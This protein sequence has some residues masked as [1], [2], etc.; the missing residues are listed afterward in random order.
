MNCE[1]AILGGGP[2]ALATAAELA[3]REISVAVV[4]DV[5]RMPWRT[6]EILPSAAQP[7]LNSLGLSPGD[8]SHLPVCGSRVFWGNDQENHRQL[9]LTVYGPSLQLVGT[10]LE[11]ALTRRASALGARIHRGSVRSVEFGED[12]H[13]LVR[14][15]AR[16]RE[17][18]AG[19]LVEARGRH[20]ESH[21]REHV[22]V[23]F[24]NLVCLTGVFSVRPTRDRTF[25]L[26]TCSLGWWYSVQVSPSRRSVSFFTDA[27][28]IPKS[29]SSLDFTFDRALTGA[30]QTNLGL[31]SRLK[32]VSVRSASSYFRKPVGDKL[33][34]VGD[35]AHC[36]D[37][38][39]SQGI[40]K[41]M[42]SGLEAADAIGSHLRQH[43]SG[44]GKYSVYC[45]R[46]FTRYWQMRQMLYS[47][48][49]RWA[50]APFW[51][52]RQNSPVLRGSDQVTIKPNS[53][54]PTVADQIVFTEKYRD[55]LRNWDARQ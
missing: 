9:D 15:G 53:W 10:S 1:V 2:A 44:L 7:V 37:P 50:K 40:W 22:P 45:L 5:R 52:R 31:C 21:H 29:A 48:E 6:G 19:I 18:C 42:E 33:L 8:I 41:A 55:D 51:A 14:Q 13:V 32:S 30:K 39:S 46:E 35:A 38:L 26:E 27:D 16:K 54:M 49:Q 20:S 23:A 4:T 17:I 36:F 3:R 34:F 47:L 12:W 43:R 28:L 11:Q 25:L 24:D